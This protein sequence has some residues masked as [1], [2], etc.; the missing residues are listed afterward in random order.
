MRIFHIAVNAKIKRI[1]WDKNDEAFSTEIAWSA[2]I[3][4]DGIETFQKLIELNDINELSFMQI[5]SLII[6]HIEYD[7]DLDY[8]SLNDE[9]IKLHTRLVR[10]IE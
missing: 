7:N 9:I 2:E 10:E 5:P 4:C 8:D 6:A 3:E 1:S